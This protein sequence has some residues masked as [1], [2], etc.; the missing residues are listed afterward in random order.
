M[1][2]PI[3]S[4]RDLTVW[5]AALT[6]AVQ[7]YRL[8]RELPRPDQFRVGDQLARS[9]T[10][11]AANIAE[12]HGRRRRAEFVRFLDIANASRCETETHLEI[13]ARLGLADSTAIATLVAQL[14]SIGRMV[15]G[16]RRSLVRS[17]N[18]APHDE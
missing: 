7:V 12:G 2:S 10:S 17:G 8:I 18:R 4:Y 5:Q 3:R 1:S 13:C 14:E 16:L 11:I 15:T 9:A 6:L